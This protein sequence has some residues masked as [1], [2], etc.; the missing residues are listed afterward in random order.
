MKFTNKEKIL[1]IVL[2]AILVI[3][4]YFLIN[5]MA[6]KTLNPP[7][8]YELVSNENGISLYHDPKYN[9]FLEVKDANNPATTHNSNCVGQKTNVTVKFQ[10]YTITAYR[11]TASNPVVPAVNIVSSDA[12]KELS[13]F[14]IGNML[15]KNHL[16]SID[17]GIVNLYD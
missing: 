13:R 17:K 4:S 5:E 10:K 9:V 2:V 14:A 1:L 3:L 12:G 11:E 16:N 6:L 7:D 15:S 8:G